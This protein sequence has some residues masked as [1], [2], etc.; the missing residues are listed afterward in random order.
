M[1]YAG[2]VRAAMVALMRNKMRSVL[3]VIGIMI[4]IA[5]VICAVA[6]GKVGQA[7]VEQQLNNLGDNFVWVEAGGRAVNG[8]RTRT[9]DTKTLTVSEEILAIYKQYGI[10]GSEQLAASAGSGV[11]EA[12][13]TAKKT[14]TQNAP[15]AP[16]SDTAVIWKLGPDNTLIPVKL[17][18]G[19]T[20]HAFTEVLA[21]LKGELKESDA[22]VIRSVVPKN[23]APGT[24][25]R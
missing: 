17:S 5:A 12:S 14:E 7:R 15:R 8:V 18:L 6:I 4:G 13:E 25:R 19:I 22:V 3:T 16:K 24:L 21:V 23:M 2:L 10:D 1:D 9:H 20:D 11:V